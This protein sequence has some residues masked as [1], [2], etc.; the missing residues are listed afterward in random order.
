ML[1]ANATLSGELA[2]DGPPGKHSPFA[3]A[4]LAR[5]ASS[6]N[7]YL[8]DLLDQVASDVKLASNGAQVPEIIARG[9]SPKLCL[10]VAGCG[11][12]LVAADDQALMVQAAGLLSEL[13][14]LK[15]RSRE[16]GD[17]RSA[18]RS[19]QERAGMTADG[20]ASANLVAVLAAMKLNGGQMAPPRLT[21]KP[22][23]HAV[24]DNFNDCADC[25]EMT[26]LP[27]G[28]FTMGSPVAEADRDRNEGPQVGVRI[29]RPFA[30]SRREIT[31]DQ[32]ETCA[33]EGGCKNYR[34]KDSGW[35]R[36]R[37]PVTYVSYD[38]AKTYV[39]WLSKKTGASY[40]LPSE[41]EWEYAARAGTT[42][43]F[44]TG[45]TITTAEANFDGSD[46]GNLKTDTYRGKTVEVGSFAPNPF[47]LYDIHG[48]LAEWTAD[49][50]TPSHAGAPADGSARGG[51][52][53]RRV[54]KG[55]AWY[56]ERSYARAAARMSYPA[57]KRLN[58]VGFR[59]VRDL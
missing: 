34:P 13:G 8:R 2:A 19:F 7:L 22:L 53:R 59:V 9:G 26:A 14:F 37:R 28:Q 56:F 17:I 12:G 39:A 24:G 47:G 11:T 6:P 55:G 58:V 31:Y 33:L 29:A 18:I 57:G 32:W 16:P 50:W 5:M 36:G 20:E 4:F 15:T 49:C 38:D 45:R 46:A 30:I 51:D 43:P 21:G 42:T 25:P 54:V 40:R 1:I 10:K 41:A 23:A 35:G 3:G 52:C 44:D 48:N 27:P